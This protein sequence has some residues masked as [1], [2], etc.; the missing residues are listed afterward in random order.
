MSRLLLIARREYLSYVRTVGF[1]LSMTLAPLGLA[2][3]IMAPGLM[4][5]ASTPATAAI[6]DLTGKG[7]AAR[8]ERVLAE[9]Q[10]R[11]AAQALR[12]AALAAGGPSASEAVSAAYARGGEPAA[13]AEL[14]RLAPRL[15]DTPLPRPALSLIAPPS[16]AASAASA[17]AA[18]E[19][20]RPYIAGDRTLP[21]GR[22]LTD[23]AVISTGE[24]G[25]PQLDAWTAT[26]SNND[27]EQRISSALERLVREDRLRE[28]GLDPTRL[29]AIEDTEVRTRTFSPK[30]EGGEVSLRD[31]LPTIIGFALGMLLWS[32]IL[33]GAGILLNSVIEEKS[34]RILEVLLA[35]A[36]T[37]E[38]LFGKILGVA[39]VTATVIGVWA[40]LG[41]V[42]LATGAPGVVRDVADVLLGGGFLLYFLLFFLGGYV[43]Y[44]ALFAA[45]GSFCETTR[46]AQSLLGPV[47]V[48]LTLPVLA[49]TVALRDPGSDLLRVLS[50]V[51]L[52]T[53]FVMVARAGSEPPMWE[54]LGSA[55]VMFLMTAGVVWLAGRAFRAGA[56]STMRLEP[57]ALLGLLRG[58]SAG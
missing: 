28:A 42:S 13:R 52:F 12:Q 34:S 29:A 32:T 18:G 53:P 30:A 56:L 16:E 23:A 33:T 49:M 2:L 14:R 26:L 39:M 3:G 43:M 21:G 45:I 35:S 44:A 6:V 37:G 51:P 47:M 25:A 24:D 17:Q 50:W 7:Y 46:E 40:T 48:L 57:R 10:G 20:L 27:A 19:A 9:Q 54:V 8:I 36:S 55:A 4:E 22:A 41:G 58:K 15:G 1:W 11:A 31:R 5:R 38:I